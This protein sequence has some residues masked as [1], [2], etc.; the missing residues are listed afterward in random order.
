MV[1]MS[2]L[3]KLVI[4]T[5][6]F[7]CCAS[8]RAEEELSLC[9]LVK[10]KTKVKIQLSIKQS[11]HTFFP[12]RA[13]VQQ[14]KVNN[15][16]NSC[17][18]KDSLRPNSDGVKTSGLK[19]CVLLFRHLLHNL[20]CMKLDIVVFRQISLSDMHLH[21][22]ITKLFMSDFILMLELCI[23]YSLFHSKLQ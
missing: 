18:T 5:S 19:S 22:N 2:S 11:T 12:L 17:E 20:T 15:H 1:N 8:R 13:V 23:F 6:P 4:N 16:E 21:H 14:K 3:S 9:G 7:G 10:Y